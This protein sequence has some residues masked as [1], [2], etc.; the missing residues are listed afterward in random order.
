M[1]PT[2]RALVHPMQFYWRR[3]WWIWIRCTPAPQTAVRVFPPLVSARHSTVKI[4]RRWWWRGATHTGVMIGWSH[5]QA[6]RAAISPGG[7]EWGGTSLPRRRWGLRILRRCWPCLA[8]PGLEGI[9]PRKSI[10]RHRLSR[11]KIF[12]SQT[13]ISCENSFFHLACGRISF[14]T[15]SK[16]SRL[17]F[18]HLFI[19][20]LRQKS[21]N[22]R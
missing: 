15:F 17:L 20:N 19:L 1:R 12:S 4:R 8:T 5:T 11:G 16:P 13:M 3:W 22:H 2:P 21:G 7:H 6:S 9:L 10:Q 14:G 18:F